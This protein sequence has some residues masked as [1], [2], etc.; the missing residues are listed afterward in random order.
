MSTT[1]YGRWVPPATPPG[2]F[3]F[4]GLFFGIRKNSA[5]GS[6]QT[7]CG[8]KLKAS[9]GTVLFLEGGKCEEVLRLLLFISVVN[10]AWG[11]IRWEELGPRMVNVRTSTDLSCIQKMEGIRCWGHGPQ[12][13]GV[14][15][16]SGLSPRE[17]KS[18]YQALHRLCEIG[19]LAYAG[20][21]LPSYTNAVEQ[22]FAVTNQFV[23]RLIARGYGPGKS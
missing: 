1:R 23:V 8:T 11:W 15:P 22:S 7:L 10:D 5:P 3:H 6:S 20:P 16:V 19:F 4:E 21:E 14:L 9:L 17:P 2:A 12:E 13:V 18:L